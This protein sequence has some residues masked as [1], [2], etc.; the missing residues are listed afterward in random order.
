[1]RIR[2]AKNDIHKI[3][4][5][6][7]SEN[8]VLAEQQMRQKQYEVEV[9]RIARKL[10]RD[11][12]YQIDNTTDK[13]DAKDQISDYVYTNVDEVLKYH[14]FFHSSEM[15]SGVN[16]YTNQ[17]NYTHLDDQR[18]GNVITPN[19][20]SRQEERELSKARKNMRE[21]VLEAFNDFIDLELM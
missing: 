12:K 10:I 8:R 11:A 6:L 13:D 2:I 20:G 4:R 17:S 7:V 21:D 19:F 3:V 18:Q 16:R 5:R 15:I 1:M 9:V 14:P